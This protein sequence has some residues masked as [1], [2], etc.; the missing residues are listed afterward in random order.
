MGESII[1]VMIAGGE[2][3][4][5]GRPKAFE[6][7]KNKMFFEYGMEALLPFTDR[8]LIVTNTQLEKQ[9]LMQTEIPVT[10]DRESFA[11]K[12]PLAGL[13]TAMTEVNGS[14]YAVLPADVP[15]IEAGVIKTLISKSQ[16]GVQA[17]IPVAGERIQPLIGVYH[18]SL[19]PVLHKL[20]ESDQL[21]MKALLDQV[22]T[23][24]V[25]FA[26]ERPFVNINRQSD[27]EMYLQPRIEGENHA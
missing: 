9:F 11:G 19:K 17:V 26:D 25:N 8:Q 15:L 7:Y 24:Y 16:E 21:K 23:V 6:M 12:G 2:S 5:F 4:R 20:L 22:N 13:Y 3:R 10:T 18:Y 14:W 27:Y 1:G